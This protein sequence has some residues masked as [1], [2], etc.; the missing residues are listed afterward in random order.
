MTGRPD[1]IHPV[2]P[3]RTQDPQGTPPPAREGIELDTDALER[4]VE[5]L[6]DAGAPAE[7]IA[8]K[9]A[10]FEPVDAAETL[11]ELEPEASIEVL[12]AMEDEAAAEALAHMDLPLAATVLVDL[13]PPEAARLIDLMEPDDAADIL[14]ELPRAVASDILAR[15]KPK[16]A[17]QLGKLALYDPRTAGGMMTTDILVVREAGSIGQ[18]IDAIKHQP[19]EESQTEVYVVD[20]Q[21]RLVGTVS[22]RSL[23]VGEDTAPVAPLVTRDIDVLTAEQ[24]R[25]EVADLFQRYDYITVP[26]VDHDRRILG[27]VTIDDVVDIIESERSEDAQ[28]LVGVAEDEGVHS[29]VREKMRGRSPWLMFNLIA[30]QAGSVVLL[31][32]HGFIEAI[33][34]VAAVYPVIANQS[35]NAGQQSLAVTLRGIVRDQIRR[36]RVPRLLMRE[37]LTG[38]F[39]GFAVGASFAAAI[40]LMHLIVPEL[41]WRLG[42][43]AGL[44]MA[45]AMPVSCL[46]GGAIPLILDRRG[47]D[48][49]TASSIFLTML[50]DFLSYGIFLSLAFLFRSWLGVGAPPLHAP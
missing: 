5:R 31:V 10:E 23:L 29:S 27:M 46:V 25:E 48:P 4:E 2:A 35:G 26:V 47:F 36:D 12:Q 50:T 20:E 9:V 40:A 34:I 16:R 22:M 45:L 33:P 7:V 32:Y 13:D 38:L 8:A 49:A 19:S 37:S 3:E 43:V 30:A 39:T 1:D 18:A 21:R 11:A 6:V 41:N 44:A 42:I 28:K 17:A 14:Q 24:A 15:L